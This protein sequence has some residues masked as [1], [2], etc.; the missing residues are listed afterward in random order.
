MAVPTS[1]ERLSLVALFVT[2]CGKLAPIASIVVFLAPL[3]TI[4]Q[5]K[6][7]HSVGSL[8]L[9]PYSTMVASGFLWTTYGVLKN[10]AEIYTSNVVGVLLGVYYVYEFVQHAPK[11]SPTLP[12]SVKQHMQG[13]ASLVLFTLL[14]AMSPLESAAEWI[15]RAG[16]VF[17][18]AMFAAPLSA[19]KTVLATQ[20]AASIPLP[21]TI[22]ATLNCVFWTTWG[23]F[24]RNDPNIYVTNAVGLLFGLAQIGLKLKFGNGKNYGRVP[25]DLPK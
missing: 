21:F 19:L 20:S 18:L 2:L 6:R 3:P 23:V 12:G 1:I 16:V 24:G 14:L 4:Q 5:I 7:D 10:Q 22:A 11:Q 13:V 9:L 25:T 15:G 17:C 8:P